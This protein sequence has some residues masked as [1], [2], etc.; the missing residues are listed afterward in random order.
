[1]ITN[2]YL[3]LI[4]LGLSIKFVSLAQGKNINDGREE[5]KSNY[6]IES[7][8]YANYGSNNLTN[9]F[10]QKLIFGGKINTELKDNV[11][12]RT[13]K[14]NRFGV[15]LN[16]ELK[17][18]EK[19]DT[20]FQIM[21][22]F[23]YYIGFGSYTNVSASYSRDL[24]ST[25]F[26]RNKQFENETANLG[27][28]NFVIQKFE[29]ITFGLQKRDRSMSMGISLIIGDRYN[30]VL[31]RKADM[32]TYPNG[33]EISMNY[34]G[35]IALSD[36]ENGSNFMGFNG[37]GLGFD[38]MTLLASKRYC[39]TVTNLGFTVWGR[40][41]SFSN[42]ELTYSFD[43][44]EIENIV[45]ATSDDFRNQIEDIVPGVSNKPF[46]TLL[47]TIFRFDKN[48]DEN[49]SL[50]SIYGI[51]YKLV[52]NY[53]PSIYAGGSYKINPKMRVTGSLAW[54]GYAGLRAQTGLYY[55]HKKIAAGIE[56]T[57]LTGIFS[58][59]GNGNGG[60]LYFL[61]NF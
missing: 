57:N 46:V 9:E 12:D 38:F 7:Y 52:S 41:P 50:Q 8:L 43:G 59:N 34:N 35:K 11:L 53:L 3:I 48:F 2:K 24:F 14:F 55:R 28:S 60:N 25:V 42:T 15:E 39:F 5:N 18:T 51:R 49:K 1:M 20:L 31:L 27:P 33:S 37:S 10:A 13:N 40:N 45:N 16:Y 17:F 19:R 44:V 32:F 36:N 56:S 61:V 23:S 58:K 21:P 29:K 54:G 22:K 30:Q 6:S 4:F 26:Y 47:P